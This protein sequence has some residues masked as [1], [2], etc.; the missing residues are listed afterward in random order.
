MLVAT[1]EDWF[2]CF[3]SPVGVVK[4]WPFRKSVFEELD[5]SGSVRTL[6]K[7]SKWSWPLLGTF[8]EELNRAFDLLAV[9]L[10]RVVADGGVVRLFLS[11]GLDSELLLRGLVARGI[12]VELHTLAYLSTVYSYINQ[13]DVENARAVAN[14]LG[15]VLNE[16]KLDPAGESFKERLLPLAV[17]YGCTQPVYLSL[18]W[19]A[20]ELLDEDALRVRVGSSSVAT[21][22]FLV[23]GEVYCQRH[24]SRTSL[25]TTPAGV[26]PLRGGEWY[27]VFREDEDGVFYR[28]NRQHSSSGIFVNDVFM[29]TPELLVAYL[30]LPEVQEV[31]SGVG[32]GEGKLSL[33][34]SKYRVLAPV[35]RSLFGRDPVARQK[36]TGY[37]R[38]PMLN[39][40]L[41]EYFKREVGYEF[42]TLKVPVR[43]LLC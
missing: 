15:L 21:S 36:L 17:R 22:V 7:V 35:F 18:L 20:G 28:W 5:Y 19:L 10:K 6:Q 29:Y 8:E 16:W 40:E 2:S 27:F 41:Q 42:S 14:S 26:G 38:A 12:P 34:S 30:R 3:S 37:E 24:W 39:Y 33:I 13:E 31:F 32:A 4:P 1:H 43:S 11:G 25:L 23:S 9:S